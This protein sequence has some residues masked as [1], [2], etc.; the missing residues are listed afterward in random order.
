[1]A[2]SSGDRWRPRVFRISRQL[3]LLPQPEGRHADLEIQDE[4]Q[5]EVFAVRRG[6]LSGNR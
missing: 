6:R 5:R 2:G 1:M 3:R 4:R